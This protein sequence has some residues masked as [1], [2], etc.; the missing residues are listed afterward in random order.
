MKYYNQSFI[1]ILGEDILERILLNPASLN[2]NN[3]SFKINRLYYIMQHYLAKCIVNGNISV[4][5]QRCIEK[6]YQDFYQKP[7]RFIHSPLL[8]NGIIDKFFGD[9]A[10]TVKQ[11][12]D[13][14]FNEATAIR[15]YRKSK[16][17]SLT[18]PEQCQ[19][20]SFF[21]KNLN[22]S[23]T[24]L[25]EVIKREIIKIINSNKKVNELNPM[26][27]EF[28]CQYIANTTM[29]KPIV[30]IGE[31]RLSLHGEEF[32]NLVSINR[33]MECS[34]ALLT[35]TVFHECRHAVQ[36]EEINN[37]DSVLGFEMAQFILFIKY[38][39]TRDYDSYHENY[40]FSSIEL[41]AEN[42][43]HYDAELFFYQLNKRDLIR[44]LKSNRAQK[45]EKRNYYAFMY[46][47]RKIPMSVDK[48]VVENMDKI[49]REHPDELKN[50]PVL[51]HF[52]HH[53]GRKKSFLTILQQRTNQAENKR[54]Y[55]YYLNYGIRNDEFAKIDLNSL[56]EENISNLMPALGTLYR[57]KVCKIIDYFEDTETYNDSNKNDFT[58][59]RIQTT[60]CYELLLAQ[61]ILSFIDENFDKIVSSYANTDLSKLR[62]N[63]PL[64]SFLYD[65][66]D[67]NPDMIKNEALKNNRVLMAKLKD[68]FQKY[69]Q[70][71]KKF[72]SVYIKQRLEEIPESTKKSNVIIDDQEM[73]LEQFMLQYA[74][75]RMDTHQKIK[76]GSEKVNVGDILYRIRK[77]GINDELQRM[78]DDNREATIQSNRKNY[79]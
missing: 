60:T 26:E 75:P 73:T 1:D 58:Y 28:Y 30:M 77:Q 2:N 53:D 42:S 63:H 4:N 40:R 57:D 46:D 64:Y 15:L 21:I 18:W 25:Q 9:Q 68:F 32:Y 61:K 17:Q 66:R 8:K 74:I 16:T 59:K 55:E 34:I 65:F 11:F 33:R 12:R 27:L 13:N 24:K 72:N 19:L 22:T 35:K 44:E 62:N 36:E 70:V 54:M 45:L 49:I 79:L 20:Y 39:N 23:N 76:I 14:Y 67:F 56:S 29:T 3:H 31:E 50:Y 71:L 43:G 10:D 38:L 48:F 69:N 51:R 52:Y 5:H 41:D 47:E 37:E 7:W 6:M 78:L